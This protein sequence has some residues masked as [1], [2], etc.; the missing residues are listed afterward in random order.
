MKSDHLQPKRYTN[1]KRLVVLDIDNTLINSIHDY[2]ESEVL[3]QADIEAINA[4]LRRSISVILASARPPRAMK[5]YWSLLGLE[6]LSIAYNGGIVWDFTTDKAKKGWHL[7]KK[8][9]STILKKAKQMQNLL[10]W[11]ESQDQLFTEQLNGEA[12]AT[13]IRRGERQPTVVTDLLSQVRSPIN[14]IIFHGE[15]HLCLTDQLGEEGYSVT[16]HI[17][18][19]MVEVRPRGVNKGQALRWL[20]KYLNIPMERVTCIGDGMDD[21][22]LFENSGLAIAMGNAPHL[23]K[24]SANKITKPVSEQGVSFA[25][26]EYVLKTFS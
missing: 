9:A 11:V 24:E 13:S 20:C 10:V 7:S 16:V 1:S 17:N 15:D 4:C 12:L 2:P 8:D 18:P 22:S 26:E 19:K 23:V 25:L 6:T 14:K 5:K 3:H 21:I